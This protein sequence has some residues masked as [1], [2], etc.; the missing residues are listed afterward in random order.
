[1][2]AGDDSRKPRRACGARVPPKSPVFVA[3]GSKL[4]LLA[5][6][7]VACTSGRTLP[8]AG[9]P[10]EAGPA[11]VEVPLVDLG[12][13][14]GADLYSDPLADHQPSVVRC[15]LAGYYLERGEL[16]LD[17]GSCNYLYLEAPAL[18]AVE[19]GRELRLSLRHFDLTAPEPASAHV[20]LLL[21]DSVQWEL[22]LD[23]PGPADSYEVS[24]HASES[25]A[26]DD[27]VRLHLHNHGQN[28][29]TFSSLRALLPQE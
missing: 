22:T 14:H 18:H 1:M 10:A 16:E 7:G 25:I 15:G 26:A 2:D 5:V 28:T 8:D 3:L 29:W 11:L 21:G 24:F 17:T 23:V 27:P 20:A 12:A 6:S 4:A 19:A 13:W 9:P